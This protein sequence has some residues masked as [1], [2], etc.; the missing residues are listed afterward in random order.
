[1]AYAS[2]AQYLETM[3]AYRFA[4]L[5][6]AT[7]RLWNPNA[8]DLPA[9][10]IL[11]ATGAAFRRLLEA[12]LTTP[13]LHE[14]IDRNRAETDTSICHSHDYCDANMV[15]HAAMTEVLGREPYICSS[16]EAGDCTQAEHDAEWVLFNHAW[17]AAA[18]R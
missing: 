14:V 4:A 10:A 8:T 11:A 3:N 12:E 1:M 7:W 18:I 9:P 17:T 16:V 5:S 15:M 13:V 2:Y 6:E